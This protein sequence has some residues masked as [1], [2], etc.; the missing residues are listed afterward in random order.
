MRTM[1]YELSADMYQL[2]Q[3]AD[4]SATVS[5]LSCMIIQ[6]ARTFHPM[7]DDLSTKKWLT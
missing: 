2:T 3:V 7:D 1:V 4:L 5:L 6:P